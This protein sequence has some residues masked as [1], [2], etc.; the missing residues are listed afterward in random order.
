MAYGAH[1][2]FPAEY[3]SKIGYMKMIGNPVV[4]KIISAFENT[5]G[6][7]QSAHGLSLR[8]SLLETPLEQIFTVDGSSLPVPNLQRAEQQLGFIQIAA[9]LF[10][11]E[12]L[13]RL[14][15][16]PMMDPR[17]YTK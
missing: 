1:G 17:D 5:Q 10:R 16:E 3:A 9:Q 15:A 11:L 13:Q 12:T 8:H 4:Q 2:G 6:D 14:I 7:A